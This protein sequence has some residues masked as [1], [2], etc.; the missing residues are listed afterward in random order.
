MHKADHT[1]LMTADRLRPGPDR[2][3]HNLHK[4][5]ARRTRWRYSSDGKSDT[6]IRCSMSHTHPTVQ[7]LVALLRWAVLVYLYFMQGTTL[8]KEAT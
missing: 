1:D 3:P 7:S 5:P 4:W 8:E 2:H 6:A